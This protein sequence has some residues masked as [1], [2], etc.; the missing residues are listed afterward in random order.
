MGTPRRMA[1]TD[2]RKARNETIF[3]R[4]NEEVRRAQE[5]LEFTDGPLPFICECED[6]SCT[7][8]IS[9][10]SDEYERVRSDPT[11][12]LLA[13][14]HPSTTGRIVEQRE[15]FWVGEKTGGAAEIAKASDPRADAPLS[16]RERRIGRN[17]VL[18]RSVNEKIEQLNQVFG[19]LTETM[20]V[21][22]ECGTMTC[23]DQIE[24]DVPTYERVRAD[25]LLFV[26]VPG[27]D[28]A[29]VEAVLERHA[30]YDI[31]RKDDGPAA[32]VATENDPR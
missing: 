31:V 12:F 19:T 10:A 2:E 30:G 16:D 6:E 21:V 14:G 27:H 17:E 9:V 32:E 24:L 11:R 20:T 7:Q 23:A 25:P 3:R 13:P 28:A 22:C 15:G 8:I 1:T 29:G 5:K 4:A 26:V 18:Y